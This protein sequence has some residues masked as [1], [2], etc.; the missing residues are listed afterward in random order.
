MPKR[1]STRQENRA[2]LESRL[3]YHL[4]CLRGH[5][6]DPAMSRLEWLGLVRNRAREI[7]EIREEVETSKR[8]SQT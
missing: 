5:A 6:T 4:G 2:P 8:N 3:A 1:K 7:R